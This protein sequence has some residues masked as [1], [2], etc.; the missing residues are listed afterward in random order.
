MESTT[1]TTSYLLV[2]LTIYLL[3][4]RD[5]LAVDAFVPLACTP[6]QLLSRSFR[7]PYTVD[8]D[9]R[10]K[11]HSLPALLDQMAEY[12]LLNG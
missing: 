2:L 10:T 12:R 9:S 4:S 11:G 1:T 5:P 8:D 7:L 6:L 3:A